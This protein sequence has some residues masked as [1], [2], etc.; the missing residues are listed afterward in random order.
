MISARSR[1]PIKEYCWGCILGF[2]LRS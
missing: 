2:H 1:P